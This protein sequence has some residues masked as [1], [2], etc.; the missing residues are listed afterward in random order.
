MA[1]GTGGILDWRVLGERQRG[2]VRAVRQTVRLL[3][4][5]LVHPSF[6]GFRSLRGISV[7]PR[8]LPGVHGRDLAW[9]CRISCGCTSPTAGRE[10]IFRPFDYA[11]Q[12]LVYKTGVVSRNV[13]LSGKIGN[14][15]VNGASRVPLQNAPRVVGQGV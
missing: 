10:I 2:G 12:K 7:H 4:R 14:N 11:L 5:V 9:L 8:G 15:P 1:E 6:L 3:P 13:V